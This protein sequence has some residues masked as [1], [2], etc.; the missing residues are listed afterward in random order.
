MK[1]CGYCGRQNGDPSEFC[2]ECG[3]PF[4]A[5][6]E[7]ASFETMRG[8]ISEFLRRPIHPAVKWTLW[9]L[10]WGAVVL[11]TISNDA[12]DL[13]SAVGFPVG[14]YGLLPEMP[15]IYVAWLGGCVAVVG[16]WILYI[17]LSLAI[18]WA[19]RMRSFSLW[20]IVFC[21]LLALNVVGCR[22]LIDT[23]SQIH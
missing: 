23:V 3:T 14:F 15:A 8:D 20:Y 10:A 21:V 12:T 6:S 19:N 9:L 17:A 2:S 1:T 13:R 18:H 16:G 11:A 5:P 7:S 4:S 22:K